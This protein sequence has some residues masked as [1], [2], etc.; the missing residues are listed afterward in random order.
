M[1]LF[2][3]KFNVNKYHCHCPFAGWVCVPLLSDEVYLP[4][5]HSDDWDGHLMGS[6]NN[7]VLKTSELCEET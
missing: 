2:W 4:P 1:T 5:A 3:L 7:N 6:G